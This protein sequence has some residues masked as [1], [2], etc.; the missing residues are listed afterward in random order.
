MTTDAAESEDVK[1]LQEINW[2][3]LQKHDSFAN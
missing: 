1:I 3:L 2:G